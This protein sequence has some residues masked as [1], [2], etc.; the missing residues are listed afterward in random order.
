MSSTETITREEE[1]IN[2]IVKAFM[3]VTLADAGIYKR[4][5]RDGL[6][7]MMEQAYRSGYAHALEKEV[8]PL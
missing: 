2:R 3:G 8:G 6:F 7:S 5:T 4:I 1:E